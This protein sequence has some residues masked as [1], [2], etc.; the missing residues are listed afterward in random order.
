MSYISIVQEYGAG[1][2][3]I[4]SIDRDGTMSGYD[5][6][7]ISKIS[8]IV[9]VPLVALGGAGSIIDFDEAIKSGATSV[10]AGSIFF[11]HGPH[12]A[13]LISYVPTR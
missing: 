11:F 6:K 13:V 2:I 12:K 3:I 7:L 10:A 4:N 9:K 1:E 5:L 8:S